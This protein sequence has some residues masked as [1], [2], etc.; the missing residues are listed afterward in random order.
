MVNVIITATL[1]HAYVLAAPSKSMNTSNTE[2]DIIRMLP[3]K[4]SR[5]SGGLES[6]RAW[7]SLGH[8]MAMVIIGMI[9]NGPL[10]I[11]VSLMQR[12]QD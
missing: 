12:R 8:T 7:K 10:E 11:E 4:S 5:R 2:P 3:M 6:L 1:L 9:A